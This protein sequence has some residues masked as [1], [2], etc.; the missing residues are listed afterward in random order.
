MKKINLFICL[1][2]AATTFAP[3]LT[4]QQLNKVETRYP[5]G[6]TK[7]LYT[8]DEKGL[9]QGV[10]TLFYNNGNKQM[11]IEFKNGEKD[12]S[13][14]SWHTNGKINEEATF[15]NNER[16]GK[17]VAYDEIGNAIEGSK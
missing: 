5:D 11:T 1:L 9:K 6:K 15:R 10:Y 3:R 2:I 17:Y 16:T 13:Y 8:V 12:G 14:F 4:A 7:E